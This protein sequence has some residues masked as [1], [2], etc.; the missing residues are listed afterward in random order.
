MTRYQV[1]APPFTLRFREM[2]KKELEAYYNWFLAAIPDRVRILAAAV[3]ETPGFEGWE[4][5]LTPESLGPLGRWLASR[6]RTRP[7]TAEEKDRIY[8]QSPPLLRQV[9]VPDL[10]LTMETYSLAIDVGMY[11]SQ[12]LL[13]NIPSLRWSHSIKGRRDAVDYGQPVLEG[14]GKVA[15]NPVRL[16]VVSAS[17]LAD[18]T[19]SA[20]GLRDLYDIWEQKAE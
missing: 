20:G 8:A 12:V 1:I 11:F 17:G 5:D 3:R 15:C 9:P 10:E 19:Y 6:V 7:R 2:S 16:M 18:G 14:F 13:N 4:P